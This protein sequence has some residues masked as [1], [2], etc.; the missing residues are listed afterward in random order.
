MER[1]YQSWQTAAVTDTAATLRRS[2]R[3]VQATPR[4]QGVV[5][6]FQRLIAGGELATGDRL[7]PE[8][9]LAQL[10]GVGRNSVRE[11][12]RQLELLGLIDSRRGDGT[13]V[14]GG[15]VS[16]L[17]GPF[18]VAVAASPATAQMVLEFRRT[19]EP[20]VAALAAS[21]VDE[22]GVEQ[23]VRA[24]HRFERAVDHNDHP[25]AA[26]SDFHAA[27]ASAT[28]NPV[29]IAVQEALASMLADFRERLAAS[30]YDATRRAARGHQAIFGAIVARDADGARE[31]ML[32]HLD[33][34]EAALRPDGAPDGNGQRW[35]DLDGAVGRS[36]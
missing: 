13:Y 30:S 7:P 23:L 20:D 36:V 27:I 17:L 14:R 2:W 4:S 8:R 24:L 31:A 22:Q 5:A 25:R 19:F 11:A 6:E 16:R 10:L 1:S 21:N 28:R 9:E 33:Q 12:L 35:S 32:A 29:V 26:D 34:V 18:R 3:P 15:D